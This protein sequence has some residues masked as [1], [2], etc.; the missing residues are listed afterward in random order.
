MKTCKTCGFTSL[1]G[2][3]DCRG[4]GLNEETTNEIFDRV[5]EHQLKQEKILSTPKH[6]L[7]AGRIDTKEIIDMIIDNVTSQYGLAGSQAFDLGNLLKYRFRAGKKEMESIKEDIDKALHY[8]EMLEE[9]L[10]V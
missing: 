9:S 10:G 3:H 2:L 1:D 7:I 5:N 4:L 8:E 6:Y